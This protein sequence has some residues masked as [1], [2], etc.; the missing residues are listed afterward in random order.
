MEV[1]DKEDEGKE[2]QD[3]GPLGDG[4]NAD[5]PVDEEA[6]LEGGLNVDCPEDD[7]AW[8]EGG[9]EVDGPEDDEAWLEEGLD[10][11]G[12][13]ITEG[14]NMGVVENVGDAVCPWQLPV[15]IETSSIAK[16]PV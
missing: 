1:P 12:S 5:C 9:L 4:L 13:D 11:D 8:L 7:E 16:S 2:E 15:L 6:W 3:E 10:V 14:E